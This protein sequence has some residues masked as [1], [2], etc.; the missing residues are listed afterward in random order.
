MF[1]METANPTHFLIAHYNDILPYC[2]GTHM[3]LSVIG[4]EVN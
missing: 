1:T 4:P 3:I 2:T